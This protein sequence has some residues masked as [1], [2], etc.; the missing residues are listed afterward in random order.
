[1][2]V[3]SLKGI[4][5]LRKCGF[6]I[7]THVTESLFID[8]SHRRRWLLNPSSIVY[9]NTGNHS[10]C[11]RENMTGWQGGICNHEWAQERAWVMLRQRRD[12]V[13]L[14]WHP[15]CA[16]VHF[17]LQRQTGV[18]FLSQSSIHSICFQAA[19]LN[20]NNIRT[21]NLVLINHSSKFMSL[22]RIFF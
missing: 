5:T 21:Y 8:V 10:Y 18:L 11:C 13:Q 14:L 9:C 2:P 17:H 1:M 22:L 19:R 16:V 7:Q 15:P 6:I 4:L 12:A 3:S 20:N